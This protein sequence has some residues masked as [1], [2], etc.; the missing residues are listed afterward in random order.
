LHSRYGTAS[1]KWDQLEKLFGEQEVI[2]LWVADMDFQAPPAVTE[3]LKARAEQGIYG[4]SI[5]PESFCDA[6]ISWQQRRHQW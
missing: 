5:R 2:P 4:Y 1:V 6:I 3:A